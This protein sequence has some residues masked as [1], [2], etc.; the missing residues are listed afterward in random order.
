MGECE[1]FRGGGQMELE[2]VGEEDMESEKLKYREEE[3][4][5]VREQ[6]SLC[7]DGNNQFFV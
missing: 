1:L 4:D 5:V 3:E 2:E 6:V 7:N